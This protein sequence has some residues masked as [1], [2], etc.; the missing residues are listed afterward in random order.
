MA[1]ALLSATC[2]PT[3]HCLTKLSPEVIIIIIIIFIVIIPNLISSHLS[4]ASPV[5]A[6]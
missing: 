4:R 2:I 3:S 1:G 6:P 5:Q